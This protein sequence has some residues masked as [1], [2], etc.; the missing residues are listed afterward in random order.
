MPE[1]LQFKIEG[2][3]E[4]TEKLENLPHK[5]AQTILRTAMKEAAQIWEEE[6]RLTVRQGWHHSRRG[7]QAVGR[8]AVAGSEVERDFGVIADNLITTSVEHSD[9]NGYAKVGP[10]KEVG[11]LKIFW[12]RYLEFGTR[13]MSPRSFMVPAFETRKQDVLD[14]FIYEARAALRAAGLPV[15]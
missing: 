15:D 4:L 12:A 2:L 3:A 7:G 14:E 1:V 8:K 6:M 5:A 13:K 10:A 9:L 11:D